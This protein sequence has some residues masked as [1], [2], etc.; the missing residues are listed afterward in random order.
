V[1][2]A[3][4]PS[5][6][7][8]AAACVSGPSLRTQGELRQTA[9]EQ[10]RRSAAA[11]C[12]PVELATAE[13]HF[14]FAQTALTLGQPFEAQQHFDFV[15][16]NVRRAAKL[17]KQ[18]KPK[19]VVVKEVGPTVVKLDEADRDGDTVND[20]DDLCPLLYG[21][22]EN[23]GC[24]KEAAQ[25]RD[26]DGVVDALDKC[27]DAAEDKD[28]FQD[29]DG[30]PDLDNDNDGLTD[31][32]DKC[33]NEAGPLSSN[34]CPLTDADQDGVSD[35]VDKCKNEPEDK[36]GFQDEDGC[37]DLD[38]DNDGIAD[39]QDKCPLLAEDKDG[40]QDE[41]GCPDLDNDDDG[42]PDDKDDC[43]LQP[44]TLENKGCPKKYALVTVTRDKIE[45]KKQIQFGTGSAAIVGNQSKL[46]LKD[47][48]AALKDSPRIKK[49]RVE[50]H[51]DS[52][53]DDVKNLKLSE[54]RAQ[55]V[56]KALVKL[57]VEGSRLE[58]VGFGEAKP[59][60]DNSKSQ[61]RAQ[62]RRTEFNIVEQ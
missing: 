62:N 57:G 35:D 6:L 3:H 29:E 33:P 28:G 50:G 12:A 42:V 1:K 59:I 18:C 13:A 2:A 23:N 5:L 38:N 34:G 52:V 19:Q 60:A 58:A 43:P 21:P 51:T 36:D 22:K 55:A 41:D 47:V 15:D 9:I 49:L 46:I 37:P 4:A 7:L 31:A 8:L 20:A 61:G 48:A 24:P 16:D 25:D 54:A 17:S 32:K 39:S 40:F 30:C 26:A 27:P 56:T 53:G 10:V 11:R 44:G 45:I 14:E